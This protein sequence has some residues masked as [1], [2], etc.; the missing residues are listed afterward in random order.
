MAYTTEIANILAE[1]IERF[2]TLNPHQVAGH[3]A[4]LDF[5]LGEVRHCLQ[6]ID[7]FSKRFETMKTAQMNYVVEHHTKQFCLDDPCCT[8]ATAS[9]PTRIPERE[10]KD[11]KQRLRDATYRFLVRCH[12]SGFIN[13][14]TLREAADSIG[15][16]I[17]L[18]D[19]NR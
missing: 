5:W 4:N 9:L 1:N 3:V 12:K 16:G 2:A 15:T 19:L 7:G 13:E 14:D 17:D 8:E 11:A 10:M 18:R 6:V